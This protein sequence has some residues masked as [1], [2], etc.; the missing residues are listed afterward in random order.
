MGSGSCRGRATLVSLSGPVKENIR[1]AGLRD[2][3]P[4]GGKAEAAFR[5]F[6]SRWLRTIQP[7]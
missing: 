7:W 6:R 5:A 2:S 1:R 4:V 3:G